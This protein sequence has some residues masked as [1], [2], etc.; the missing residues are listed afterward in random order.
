MS[1]SM[2]SDRWCRER[3]CCDKLGQKV[4]RSFEHHCICEGEKRASEVHS[5]AAGTCSAI[6]AGGVI[7]A[8]KQ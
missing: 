8:I 5:H 3:D 4:L 7:E 6:I 2:I 1:W